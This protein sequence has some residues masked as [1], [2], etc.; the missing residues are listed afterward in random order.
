M[1][2][3][4]VA[5]GDSSTEGLN[6]RDGAGGFRGWAD[7]LAATVAVGSPGLQ[8]A[9]LAVR[10]R[11]VGQVRAEQLPTAMELAPDLA[12]VFAGVNDVMRPR[13]DQGRVLGDLEACFAGLRSTGATVLTITCADPVDANPVA[14]PLRKRLLAYNDGVRAAAVRTGVLVA[15]VAAVGVASD[16]RLWSPD[17]L[18]ANSEGHRRIAAALAEQLG[19]GD[20]SWTAPLPPEPAASRRHRLRAEAVW[21]RQHFVPFLVRHARG[22]SMGDGISAKRPV[23]QEL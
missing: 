22:R 16:P 23:L 20:G 18:H 13:Y 3:R 4:Y 10:G 12:T 15:D 5:I 1:F 19:L 21:W 8:Y 2:S 9:N 17:R 14:R 7:R 11:L 6:D